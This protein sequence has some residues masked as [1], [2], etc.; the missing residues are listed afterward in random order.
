MFLI[1]CI[2]IL[3]NNLIRQIFFYKVREKRSKNIWNFFIHYY[4]VGPVMNI[5]SCLLVAFPINRAPSTSA[6][7]VARL[8]LEINKPGL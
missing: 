6:T 4:F 8:A 5:A 7:G 2:T 1:T 3:K